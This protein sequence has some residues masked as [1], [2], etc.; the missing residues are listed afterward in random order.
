MTRTKGDGR[1]SNIRL[2]SLR[3]CLSARERQGGHGPRA[4]GCENCDLYMHTCGASIKAEEDFYSVCF[5]SFASENEMSVVA[6]IVQ[7]LQAIEKKKKKPRWLF[8]R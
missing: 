1:S 6:M 3:L 8:N 5:L 4:I 2:R 7:V